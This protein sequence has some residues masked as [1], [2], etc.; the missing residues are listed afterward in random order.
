MIGPIEWRRRWI[1][2]WAA[3]GERHARGAGLATPWWWLSFAD[4]NRPKGRQFL[5][6]AIVQ[7][8]SFPIAVGVAHMLGI[9]PGGE[10]MGY[11]VP[12]GRVVP[13]P[14]REQLLSRADIAELEEWMVLMYGCRKGNVLDRSQNTG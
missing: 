3:I 11:P 9:N 2:M 8:Y 12:P 6:V 7:A 10:V 1:M 14:F 13:G 4:G 5:G